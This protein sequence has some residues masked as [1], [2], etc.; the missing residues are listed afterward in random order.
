MLNGLEKH[1]ELLAR[2]SHRSDKSLQDILFR[3][4][5]TDTKEQAIVS[6]G[7]FLLDLVE[8][9]M[10]QI[11]CGGGIGR[12]LSFVLGHISFGNWHHR[13][14]FWKK[15]FFQNIDIYLFVNF[16]LCCLLGKSPLA[17]FTK[18]SFGQVN[19]LVGECLLSSFAA[20]VVGISFHTK[21]FTLTFKHNTR[22]VYP[23]VTSVGNLLW[24][25][26]AV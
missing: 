24:K 8:L 9:F 14:C 3:E 12:N 2:K 20:L 6:V 13:F 4:H 19:F 23:L 15:Q 5:S 22:Q 10:R 26:P 11:R 18:I 25:F 7:W 21:N 1:W 16:Q 17:K